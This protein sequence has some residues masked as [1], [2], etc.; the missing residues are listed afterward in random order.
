MLFSRGSKKTIQKKNVNFLTTMN[1]P[2]IT[3]RLNA[4]YDQAIETFY[5]N[6]LPGNHEERNSTYKSVLTLLE[7]TVSAR[8]EMRNASEIRD[9]RD[10]FSQY[11]LL[12]RDT[13]QAASSLL[14]HEI[15]LS[16]EEEHL[17]SFLGNE[18]SSQ[19]KTADKIFNDSELNII[20]A[21]TELIKIA[22]P[23]IIK[24]REKTIK[25]FSSEDLER[26]Q[27]AFKEFTDLYKN[28]L[29]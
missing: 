10:L 27:K 14:V 20:Q 15:M 6:T 1:I 11:L 13:I 28:P 19:F 22:T 17:S 25:N 12:L 5:K 18:I 4:A 7:I 8:Q 26:Y 16:Q 3:A 24:N 21:T 23:V 2:T 29:N 9:Q